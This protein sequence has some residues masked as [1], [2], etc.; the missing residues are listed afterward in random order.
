MAPFASL[1]VPR[2]VECVSI[3]SP[4]GPLS[5]YHGPPATAPSATAAPAPPVRG[6]RP[7]AA[8]AGRPKVLLVPGFTGSKED[9]RLPISDL[10]DRGFEVLAYSQRG[11][12]DSAAPTGA[13]AY[14]LGGFAGDV[15]AI[16]SAWGAGQRVHLLGHS[17]GGVVARAAAI[18][19]PGLFASL[20]LFSSGNTA[21]GADRP[22]PDP[23][24]AGPA[25]R[26]RVLAAV[27][28]GTDFT[29]PGL[30]WEEFMRVRAL[31]TSTGNLMGIR[32]ILADQ[33]PR[34]AELRATGLPIHVVYG[35]ED[36]AWPVSDYRREAREVGAVETPIP[37][38]QHS[39]QT[40]RPTVWADAVS[41]FWLAVDS[42]H[43][44]WQM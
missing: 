23:V 25:G 14:G 43:L 11:Q 38:A 40:Q 13:G 21:K 1:P 33:R 17:F 32:A 12:A 8:G 6:P 18:A 2:G 10:V 26:E 31:A 27:F 28:P 39:A 3:P 37:G 36:T 35:A 22:V 4:C 44:V 15:T 19:R 30:G 41:R 20:T 5:A 29:R 34:S 9:F 7:G 24:P 16:A 42:G